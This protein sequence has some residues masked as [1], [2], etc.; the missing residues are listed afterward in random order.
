MP[1]QLAIEAECDIKRLSKENYSYRQ[2]KNKLSEESVDVSVATICRV[3]KNIGIGRQSIA[4][5]EP[6][7]KKQHI[8]IKRTPDMLKKVKRLVDKENPAS[9][10]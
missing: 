6:V 3:L 7:P 2:I 1:K 8:P 9:A 10:I 4:Q 5:G